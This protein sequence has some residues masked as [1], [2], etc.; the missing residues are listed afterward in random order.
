MGTGSL[1][2][3]TVPVIIAVIIRAFPGR[4]LPSSSS[5]HGGNNIN[6][7]LFELAG[8]DLGH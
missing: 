7:S 8:P 2:P 4:W 3:V 5:D 1:M 6:S